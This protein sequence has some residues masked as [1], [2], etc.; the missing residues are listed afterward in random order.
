M[1][2]ERLLSIAKQG[3]KGTFQKIVYRRTCKTF[4]G[5]RELVEKESTFQ[6]MRQTNYANRF[7][8][9]LGVALG[10]R[11]APKLPEWARSKTIDGI[12]LI[13]HKREGTL[14]FPVNVEG[15]KPTVRWFLNGQETT[16][17]QVYHLILASE[18][19]DKPTKK[20]LAGKWQAC[21][22]R[23]KVDNIVHLS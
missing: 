8:V 3:K 16:L 18:K 13:E 15:M 2:L 17:G 4:K 22:L 20:E 6:A 14:Y 11:E 5:T 23:L 1:E 9:A 7:F 21:H 19:E 10:F 12:R